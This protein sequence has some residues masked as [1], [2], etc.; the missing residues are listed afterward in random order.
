MAQLN[1]NAADIK[2]TM[3]FFDSQKPSYNSDSGLFNGPPRRMTAREMTREWKALS[4]QSKADIRN[5]IGD[6]SLTY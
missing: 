5:G 2:V 3:A 1:D 6:G 4:D